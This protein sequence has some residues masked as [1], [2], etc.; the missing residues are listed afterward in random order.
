MSEEDDM[1]PYTYKEMPSQTDGEPD[2]GPESPQDQ[3]NVTVPQRSLPKTNAALELL[4]AG[5]PYKSN[6]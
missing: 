2:T 3:P 4:G 6:N 1:E 5:H